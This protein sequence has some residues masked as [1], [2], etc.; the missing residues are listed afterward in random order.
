MRGITAAVFVLAALPL[1]AQ[2]PLSFPSTS[3]VV[4]VDVVVTDHKGQPVSGLTAD[5]FRITEDGRP[6]EIVQFLPVQVAAPHAGPV[7]PAIRETVSSNTTK[8][9]AK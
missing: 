4:T 9:A 3:E 5:R 7:A 6:Q 8:V 1:C 2:E